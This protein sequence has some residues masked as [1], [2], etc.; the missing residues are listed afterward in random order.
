[1]VNHNEVGLEGSYYLV[2]GTNK[3][4]SNVMY[5]TSQEGLNLAERILSEEFGCVDNNDKTRLDFTDGARELVYQRDS[6]HQGIAHFHLNLKGNI[7]PHIYLHHWIGEMVP[8][9][10][11]EDA[12][13][14]ML[15]RLYEAIQPE[16]VAGVQ[17]IHLEDKLP[18]QK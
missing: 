5:I 11:K 10:F 3:I 13:R 17:G 8:E 14:K 15:E 6:D 4:I 1:M 7:G 9:D 18:W 12:T 16:R 2:H